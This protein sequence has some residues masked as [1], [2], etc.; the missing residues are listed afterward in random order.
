MQTFQNISFLC[1]SGIYATGTQPQSVS[2]IAAFKTVTKEE[3]KAIISTSTESEYWTNILS[4][5]ALEDIHTE[6]ITVILGLT[7]QKFCVFALI[8]GK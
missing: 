7:W 6:E 5:N 3:Q 1:I 2:P 8:L 4:M